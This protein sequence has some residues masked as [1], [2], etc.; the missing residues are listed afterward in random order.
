MRIGWAG[1][2]ARMR[3]RNAYRTLVGRPSTI[4]IKKSM[5]MRWAGNVARM[6][7]SNA[8]KTLVGWESQNEE[9]PS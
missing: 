3:K 5:R 8:Y 1:N 9:R 7:K 6:R 4:R 2:V